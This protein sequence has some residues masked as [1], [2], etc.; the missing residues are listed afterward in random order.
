MTDTPSDENGILRAVRDQV[1]RGT[2]YFDIERLFGIP[3]ARAEQM[4][5]DYYKERAKGGNLEEA[6]FLQLERF[7]MMIGPMMDRV[8]MGDVKAADALT[9]ILGQINETL[10][11]VKEQKS[12]EI[13]IINQQQGEAVFKMIDYV[14]TEQLKIIQSLV[15]DQQVLGEIE[16]RW[17]ENAPVVMGRAREQIIDAEV[18]SS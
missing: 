8:E 3:A 6:R 18:I 2:S 10:G 11:L 14:L 17:D 1:R 7:E 12:I 4:M 13:T 16:D 15:T 5:S 9:K